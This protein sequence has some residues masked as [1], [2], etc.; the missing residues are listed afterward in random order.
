MK[1]LRVSYFLLGLMNMGL[2]FNLPL[3]ELVK[4]PL[5]TA[6]NIAIASEACL[7]SSTFHILISLGQLKKGIKKQSK[8]FGKD[9]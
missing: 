5:I 2:K 3:N 9:C 6:G 8:L 1:K 7:I 4:I